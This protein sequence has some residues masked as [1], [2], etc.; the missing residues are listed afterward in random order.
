MGMSMEEHPA[1]EALR[2]AFRAVRVGVY[3]RRSSQRVAVQEAVAAF[4]AHCRWRGLLPEAA[5]DE[6]RAIAHGE[7][8]Y[9]W[10]EAV[11]DAVRWCLAHYFE[12]PL[13]E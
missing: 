1:A 13:H 2:Q 7:E 3:D 12:L 10:S 4:A 8:L 6:I 9:P 5:A 11:S